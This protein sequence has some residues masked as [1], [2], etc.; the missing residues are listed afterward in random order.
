MMLDG[1]EQTNRLGYLWLEFVRT[2]EHGNDHHLTIGAA[3]RGSRVC[4]ETPCVAA[5]TPNAVTSRTPPSSTATPTC[6]TSSPGDAT[7]EEHDGIKLCR[8]VDAH[9]P[10][11]IAVVGERIEAE[12]AEARDRLTERERDVFQRF[13]TGD[14]GDHRSS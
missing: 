1:F 14:L 5:W 11:D 8:L 2:N 12:A 10:R 4:W 3:I 9:G 6:A 13:L 7:I